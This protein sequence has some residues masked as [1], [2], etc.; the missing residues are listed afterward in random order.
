MCARGSKADEGIL[1]EAKPRRFEGAVENL[2]P[3][4]PGVGG[5]FGHTELKGVAVIVQGGFSGNALAGPPAGENGGIGL[6]IT[7]KAK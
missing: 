3:I 7:V 1:S 2:V 4:N 5:A 6:V